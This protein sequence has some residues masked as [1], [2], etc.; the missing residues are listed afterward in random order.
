MNLQPQKRFSTF[1]ANGHR[2]RHVSPFPFS[3]E[4]IEGERVRASK[5]ECAQCRTATPDERRY[6]LDR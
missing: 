6:F 1:C 4:M 2:Q 5:A 3:R